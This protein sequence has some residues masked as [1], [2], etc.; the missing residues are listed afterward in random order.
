MSLRFG[1]STDVTYHRY[2]EKLKKL[3]IDIA[4]IKIYPTRRNGS[5]LFG[6]IYGEYDDRTEAVEQI[7]QLPEELKANRPIPRTM[8]GIWND[9]N[10]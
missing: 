5:I 4:Q 6:V 2:L 3:D 7:R 1:D 8:G 10:R 9:I